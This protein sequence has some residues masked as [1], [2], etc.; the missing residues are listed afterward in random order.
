M[1]SQLGDYV[2]WR[3]QNYVKMGTSS[4]P[5]SSKGKSPGE[6]MTYFKGARTNIINKS[7]NIFKTGLSGKDLHELEM[8]YTSL[9]F[10]KSNLNDAEQK[11]IDNFQKGWVKIFN[12]FRNG[13]LILNSQ[14]GIHKDSYVGGTYAKNKEFTSKEVNEILQLLESEIHRSGNKKTNA[15]QASDKLLMEKIKAK[16]NS[17]GGISKESKDIISLIKERFINRSYYAAYGDAFEDGIY[18]AS[19][20]LDEAPIIANKKVYESLVKGSQR[21]SAGISS[22][23][24]TDFIGD[25]R[26]QE[27]FNKKGEAGDF[28]YETNKTQDKVDISFTYKGKLLNM[29][30]KYVGKKSD[31]IAIHTGT[32]FL[33]LLQSAQTDIDIDWF[34][35]Y[36][37]IAVEPVD[38]LYKN[39]ASA[40]A[41]A[42][43]TFKVLAA[44]KGLTGDIL[45]KGS[46]ANT[47]AVYDTAARRVRIVDM[48][49][50]IRKLESLVNNGGISIE[51]IDD[52]DLIPIDESW[53]R[54]DSQN[55][56]EA[57]KNRIAGIIAHLH[58]QKY[59]M[60]LDKKQLL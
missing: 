20:I 39:Y 45:G 41:E 10:P 31:Q 30:A 34:N 35:H 1:S 9:F 56:I 38:T 42:I 32:S 49:L 8:F 36:L 16:L 28:L 18:A 3:R 25:D 46:Q 12:K 37:N 15:I 43:K 5:G 14:G 55:S 58:K 53:S 57:A 51:G 40:R 13:N 52:L 47:F 24:V 21:S 44:I 23:F 17:E 29:S 48:S 4:T 60:T 6:L 26:K 50:A 7:K 54:R 33:V 19:R 59:H 27:I 22:A 2:H 11:M